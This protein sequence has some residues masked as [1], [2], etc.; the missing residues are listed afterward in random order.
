MHIFY[1]CVQTISWGFDIYLKATSM[2]GCQTN[3]I[4]SDI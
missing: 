2:D 1:K 3:V 4:N